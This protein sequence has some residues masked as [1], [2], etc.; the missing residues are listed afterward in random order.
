M[1][2]HEKKGMKPATKKTS[3]RSAGAKA[4]TSKPATKKKIGG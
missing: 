3:T 1:S 4:K 2:H